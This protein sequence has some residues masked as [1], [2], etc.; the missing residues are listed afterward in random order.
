[1]HRKCQRASVTFQD[2]LVEY[3]SFYDIHRKW[4]MKKAKRKN[5][6]NKW[7][8]TKDRFYRIFSG[9]KIDQIPWPKWPVKSTSSPKMSSRNGEPLS[10]RKDL[11][12]VV[13][14][15]SMGVRVGLGCIRERSCLPRA[16]SLTLALFLSGLSPRWICIFTRFVTS[17]A[18]C[19]RGLDGSE[20]FV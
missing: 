5:T 10:G 8:W 15:I 12:I 13:E 1:M 4:P 2:L 18:P 9:A 16:H 11:Y 14:M 3:S 17:W 20:F 7:L 19:R 6:T